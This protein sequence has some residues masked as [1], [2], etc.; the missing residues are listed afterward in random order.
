MSLLLQFFLVSCSPRILSSVDDGQ[1]GAGIVGC[2]ANGW[3]SENSK[4]Y[5]DG[6]ATTLDSSGAGTW[7]DETYTAGVLKSVISVDAP[8]SNQTA[9]SG[10]ATF[11]VSAIVSNRANLSYQWQKQ[12]GGSGEFLDLSDD[13]NISGAT[14]E[15]L[16]LS[17][18]NRSDDDGDVYRCVMR[19][20][21]GADELVLSAVSLSVNQCASEGWCVDE[22]MYYVSGVQCPGVNASGNG[23]SAGTGTY[24]LA[25]TGTTLDSSGNGTYSGQTYTNG[26]LKSV[27]TIGTQPTNQT[28]NGGPVTF[29]VVASVT[30]EDTL[31]YQWA[32]EVAEGQFSDVYD[33]FDEGKYTG[34]R[35]DTLTIQNITIADSGK[36]YRVKVSAPGGADDVYSNLVL[37]TVNQCASTG[38]CV[39]ESMY[40]VGGVACAGMDSSGD[41]Y[42]AGTGT[43]YLSGT[44]T[45]LDSSGNGTYSGQTYTNGSLKS[46]ITIGTPPTNQTASGGSASF[47]VS[48]S[49]TNG[50]TPSYQWEK[51]EGGTGIFQT[52][53]NGTNVSG[54]TSS[55]LSLSNLT[56]ADDNGDVYRVV[57]SATGGA[58]DDNSSGATLTVNSVTSCNSNSSGSSICNQSGTC[59]NQGGCECGVYNYINYGDTCSLGAPTGGSC[60]SSDAAVASCTGD[61][62]DG[63]QSLAIDT[64]RQGPDDVLMSLK[65]ANGTGDFKIWKEK[66]GDRVLNSSGLVAN[67]WQQKLNRAGTA[68]DGDLTDTSV[69]Q[70]IGGRVCPQNVFLNY[71]NM[72]VTNRCLYYD[73]GN[74][75]QSIDAASP[76]NGGSSNNVE[77]E[78]WIT[79][80][81]S[82]STGRGTNSSYYEGNIKTCADKRMRLPTIYETTE[83]IVMWDDFYSGNNFKPTGDLTSSGG[84]LSSHPTWAGT[85]GVP[86]FGDYMNWTA[87]AYNLDH[88]SYWNWYGPDTSYVPYSRSNWSYVRCVLPSHGVSSP[89]PDPPPDPPGG[90][91]SGGGS[92]GF[93]ANCN[94]SVNWPSGLD[95]DF[96]LA[97]YNSDH[98]RAG[99]FCD[100]AINEQIW[101][102][103][104]PHGGSPWNISATFCSADGD[105]GESGGLTI[106]VVGA[107]T[108]GSYTY[109]VSV[110]SN[111]GPRYTGG[112]NVN[113]TSAP[114]APASGSSPDYYG[115]INLNFSDD[116]VTVSPF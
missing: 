115:N 46:V 97:K 43:Y 49:V 42:C 109:T 21:G 1:N 69:I 70:A 91:G 37:L 19:A 76:S 50:G 72:A 5:K 7:N 62:Y 88:N 66:C 108:A 96:N 114:L 77:A 85:N 9:S 71:D 10:G 103:H 45:T 33:S 89:P 100:G 29:S 34:S 95:V 57:V 39:D 90:G 54:A 13:E 51:Q 6:V 16:V 68:F 99:C 15:T 105:T 2:S 86:S 17:N 31:A 107:C 83:D 18:L 74:D 22:S 11:S 106:N 61:C 3:C 20:T 36:H 12:E 47:S 92:S 14:S 63:A 80:W 38:W 59:L 4:Y 44:A 111:G 24:Y 110:E 84:S 104:G 25:G 93:S 41:G 28:S 78:D 75:W 113:Y 58:T 98:G 87:S 56:H 73:T 79:S 116:Y 35:S 48:A 26:S 67:G 32:V 53:S 30:N 81:D 27:I 102:S 23:Y 65:Y 52:V 8:P 112:C 60:Q 101:L 55:T 40:Y 82:A 64:E 94:S